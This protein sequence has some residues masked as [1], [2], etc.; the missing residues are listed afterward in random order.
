MG[1]GQKT[2]TFT[3]TSVAGISTTSGIARITPSVGLVTT[4]GGVAAPSNVSDVVNMQNYKGFSMVLNTDVNTPDAAVF[5]A[6]VTDLCTSVAHGFST[7][8]KGQGTTTT[9]L[10]AGL[11]TST[12]YFVIKKDADTF[13][14]ASSLA[15]A[16]AGTKIDI[17]DTGTGVHTFNPTSI[18]GGGYTLQGS[19]DQVDWIT[20][21][22]NVA[23][24]IDAVAGITPTSRIA[25]F[26]YYRV[27]YAITAG[28]MTCVLK[29]SLN[30]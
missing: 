28:Q 21:V 27:Y 20:D 30:T 3:N 9:T 24:T 2:L 29:I 14:L 12:D 15:N 13:W 22:A 8:M 5:T 16:L 7:G 19:N 23:I 25:E 10:P 17:T 6:A 18:A 11:S 4:L 26:K 1:I